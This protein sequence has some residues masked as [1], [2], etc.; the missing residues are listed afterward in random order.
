MRAESQSDYRHA[1]P[2]TRRP[3]G[4]RMNLTFRWFNPDTDRQPTATRS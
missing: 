3:V 2:K 1:V 4:P